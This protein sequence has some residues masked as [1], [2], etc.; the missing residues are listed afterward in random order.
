VLVGIS[1]YGVS[2]PPELLPGFQRA[3]QARRDQVRAG[4]C[5]GHLEAGSGVN[6]HRVISTIM[7]LV[8]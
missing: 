2:S 1:T 8:D 6:F 7:L 4:D 5:I 3:Y